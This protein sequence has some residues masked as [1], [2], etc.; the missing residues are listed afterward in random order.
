LSKLDQTINRLLALGVVLCLFMSLSGLASASSFGAGYFDAN[1]PFGTATSIA[2]AISGNV[3]L[4][5][6]PSGSTFSG[7]GSNS[8]TVTTDDV[9]GYYLYTYC[10]SSSSLINGSYTIPASINTSEAAL[11]N[12]TWGYN[13]DGSGNYIGFTT[14]PVVIKSETG[15]Y[16]SG[17]T[18]NITYG[19]LTNDATPDGSYSASVN[20]TVAA[21][22]D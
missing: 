1:V 16:I 6:V 12:N 13:T 10:H 5:L 20:Y 17:D 2:V 18:T 7:S 22:S 19:V 4:T 15:P 21:M 8:V 3:N 14:K 11:T 9:N